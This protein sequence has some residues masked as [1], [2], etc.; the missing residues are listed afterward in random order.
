MEVSLKVSW[1]RTISDAFPWTNNCGQ[2]FWLVDAMWH[3]RSWV[4]SQFCHYYCEPRGEENKYSKHNGELLKKEGE[5]MPEGQY[6]I[7]INI[8]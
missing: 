7:S 8:E 1:H 6:P 5:W 4:W 2:Q 3:L